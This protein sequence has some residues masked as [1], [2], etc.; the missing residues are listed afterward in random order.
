MFVA[1]V[2]IQP[3]MS[4]SS[5]IALLI[6][7][8]VPPVIGQWENATYDGHLYFVDTSGPKTHSEAL[9]LC[10]NLDPNSYLLHLAG[11]GEIR[12]VL[13][14]LL[15]NGHR[16]DHQFRGHQFVCIFTSQLLGFCRSR[17]GD[18]FVQLWYFSR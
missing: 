7:L 1:P 14:K 12:Y 16:A 9:S 13:V 8:L 5:W 18:T 15:Q 3:E 11:Y 2:K 6:I 4:K 17:I 10:A